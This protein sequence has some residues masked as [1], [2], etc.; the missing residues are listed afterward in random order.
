MVRLR[1]SVAVHRAIVSRLTSDSG[2]FDHLTLDCGD[3]VEVNIGLIVTPGRIEQVANLGH[4]AVAGG[5]GNL[6][7]LQIDG[8]AVRVSTGTMKGSV[9]PG[10][11]NNQ[12]SSSGKGASAPGEFEGSVEGYFGVLRNL[13]IWE[14]ITTDLAAVNTFL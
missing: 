10:L 6:V 12:L 5:R 3:L 8:R 7:S 11:P 2:R 4:R 1:R 14:Y 13:H 9:S